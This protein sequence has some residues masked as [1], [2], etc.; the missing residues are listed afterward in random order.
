MAQRER[1][2]GVYPQAE[3]EQGTGISSKRG[4]NTASLGQRVTDL[5]PA[6][7]AGTAPATAAATAAAAAAVADV[8]ARVQAEAGPPNK[9]SAPYLMCA[10]VQTATMKHSVVS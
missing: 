3:D 5:P 10:C 8:T 7:A 9:R 6:P 4:F 2:A 1:L